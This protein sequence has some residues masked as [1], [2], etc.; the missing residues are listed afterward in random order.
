MCLNDAEIECGHFRK[1]INNCI[2]RKKLTKK[3]AHHTAFYVDHAHIYI[4]FKL[5]M[6]D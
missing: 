2:M 6:Q 4:F 1:I 3:Y 5:L